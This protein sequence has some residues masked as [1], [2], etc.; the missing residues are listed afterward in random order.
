VEYLPMAEF[1]HNNWTSETTGE[2]P[3]KLLM[4]YH[5]RADWTDKPS[6]LPQVTRRLEEFKKARRCAQELMIKAQSMWVKYKDT[7]KYKEGDLVWL[8]GKRLRTNQPTAKLAPRRH[9]PFKIKQVMSPVNYR[10]ELP[11][12]WSIH[13]V[14]HT[15]LLTPYRET[16][17]HGS[18]YIR[19]PPELIDG[20]E[21]YTVENI[22]DVRRFGRRRKLQYL[23]KWD[24]YPDSENQWVDKDDVFADDKVADF[25]KSNPDRGAHIR[26]VEI[27]D[28]LIPTPLITPMSANDDTTIVTPR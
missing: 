2:S 22:L 5:P 3:F 26:R 16:I 18:N 25:Y 24:G 21:Q 17:T 9:G 14:F 23:V 28:S 12:Q 13:S 7:P 27:P 19:P 20:E 6:P 15:D 11:T 10:L 4:G 1:A 8:E